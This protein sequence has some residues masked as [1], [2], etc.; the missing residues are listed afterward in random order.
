MNRR[1]PVVARLALGVLVASAWTDPSAARQGDGEDWARVVEDDRAI[2]IETDLIEA[3]IPKNSPKH[4]MTGI[5]KGTF[6]DKT[7]G[8]REAGDGLMV[9]DWLMEPGSDAE[10]QEQVFAPDGDGVGRYTWFENET[11]PARREYALMAH[12]SSHRKRMVEG[13]QLCHRMKPVEPEVIRGDDFVAVRTTYRFE[14]A[15]PGRTPG[16]RWTQLIVF[17]KGER[18]FVLMDRVDSVNDS[19]EL[20]LRNDTPGCVRHE[21]GDTFS[22]MYLSYLGGPDGVRIPSG[23][24]FNPFPPDLKF[25]Y[26]RDTHRVPEHFIRAYHLRDPETGADGPWL[27]GLTLDPS[28]VYEAWCSQRPGGIIVMIEEI[29]GRPTKAGESFSAAH[30]VGY[31][32]DI[33]AMH[34]VYDRYEG[35][36]GLVVDEGGWRLVGSTPTPGE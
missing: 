29:H 11:D 23:E 30:V 15:A 17:P 13:P 3:V 18:Y 21:Q 22:E 5:E 33:E 26:R 25:G 2:T 6:L 9:I 28:V 14:Y 27:A 1:N 16:S 20:F 19:P 8:F 10:W 24:F 36:T 32:D 4:W 12:G 34:E 35:H 7:T 31:F